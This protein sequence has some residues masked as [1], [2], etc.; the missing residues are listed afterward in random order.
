[1]QALVNDY[2]FIST[3]QK[4]G[5]IDCFKE[6]MYRMQPMTRSEFL[7]TFCCMIRDEKGNDD[8]PSLSTEKPTSSNSESSTP[9]STSQTVNSDENDESVVDSTQDI[10]VI[11][12]NLGISFRMKTYILIPFVFI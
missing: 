7:T 4:T 1:M 9:G 11:F 6:G 12:R 3:E 8:D 5:R 10:E 2:F